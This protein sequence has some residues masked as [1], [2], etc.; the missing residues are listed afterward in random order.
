MRGL[1]GAINVLSSQAIGA[2]NSQLAGIWLQLGV[3]LFAPLIGL[4]VIG[5]WL[6]TGPI[7]SLFA[8]NQTLDD[9]LG[10]GGG[11]GPG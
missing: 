1:G 6:L 5:L 3:W 2:G 8:A 11:D 9:E 10:S 7:V 4:L